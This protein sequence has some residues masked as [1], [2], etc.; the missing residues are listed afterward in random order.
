MASSVDMTV[1]AA[2]ITK[3]FLK[4]IQIGT[5]PLTN[6]WEIYPSS[7]IFL[8]KKVGTSAKISLED[9]REVITIQ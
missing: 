9:L 3:L 5:L 6:N 4:L 1:V 2:A 7:S 8:G